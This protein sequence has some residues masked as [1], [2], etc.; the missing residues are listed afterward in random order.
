M[1]LS[2]NIKNLVIIKQV[3]LELA[4]GF[5]IITGETGSG[6][7]ILLDCLSL[8]FGMRNNNISVFKGEERGF[9]T[10]EFDISENDIVKNILESQEIEVDQTI[11]VKR[12]FT[13]SGR[14]QVFINDEPISLNLLKEISGHLMEMYGQHD[15]SNLL[16]KSAHINILDEFV[17]L[18]KEK[19]E[20]REI[21]ENLKK[22]KLEYQKQKT[23]AEKIKQ[24]E[25]YL[26]FV[27]SELE[28]ADVK[29]GEENEL[30][31]Q[32]SNLQNTKRINETLTDA[33]EILSG[34]V[35]SD[36][37]K[38]QRDMEKLSQNLEGELSEKIL[39]ITKIIDKAG[40]D[41]D[42][43]KNDIDDIL[44]EYSGQG[45]SLEEIEDR[46]HEIRELAR[47]HRKTPDELAEYTDSIRQKL[48]LLDSDENSIESLSKEIEKLSSEYEEAALKISDK[49]QKGGEDMEKGIMQILPDLKM[50]D[51]K[52]K[53]EINSD[54]NRT[55]PD[56]IDE[57]TLVASINPGQPFTDISKTASGGELSRLMLALKII[58]SKNSD[59]CV[60][61]DEIDTGISGAT[62]EAV[63]VK[64]KELSANNQVICITHQPQVASKAD[65]HFMVAKSSDKDFAKVSVTELD[66]QK[67]NEEVARLI[68]GVTITDEARAA[69][70]RLKVS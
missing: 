51:A 54:I 56:G 55:S 41:L 29:I 57:V 52:F 69:A 44:S 68:S 4:E 22:K 30:V 23:E 70:K 47:K 64:L 25:E 9:V 48:S 16:N 65:S 14:S 1:L 60:I 38:M 33:S 53:V 27:L 42:E 50:K 35:L 34:N 62:A 37:Y 15:F 61:F 26:R 6:K 3:A 58:L 18:A 11:I 31:S 12:T 10:A 32:K 21:Y 59:I 24:E 5:N 40:I 46:I 17:G 43:T 28:Q 20:L 2:L 66:K 7:S 36:I 67:A 49:R 19:S 45:R 13:S 63:G 39:N 8:C